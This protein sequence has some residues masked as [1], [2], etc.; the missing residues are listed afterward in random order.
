MTAPTQNS[1]PGAGYQPPAAEQVKSSSI[2]ELMREVTSDL[3][4][5]MRQEVELAK[6]EIRQEGKK[7]GK[8]AGF[9]GGAGFGGYMVAL[10]LSLALWAGLSNVMDAGWA[11]LIVAVLWAA[12]AALLYTMGRKNAERIRGLKQ[13]NDSVQRIPD[14]LKPHPEGVTR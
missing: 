2:G 7:A 4:T 3:S 11:G 12:I 5:L 8:A 14:A 6:A 9:F 1:G 10:F 13:T